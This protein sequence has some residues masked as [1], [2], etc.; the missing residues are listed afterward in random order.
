MRNLA[1]IGLVLAALPAPA[2]SQFGGCAV[3]G[4]WTAAAP[5]GAYALSM[6][7]DA[8]GILVGVAHPG[9]SPAL[10]LT[11]TGQRTG[12][13]LQLRIGSLA[14]VGAMTDC[15]TAPLIGVAGLTPLPL[16]RLRTTYCGDGTV[17]TAVEACDDGNFENG[18][19]CGIACTAN[20]ACGDVT[21][22]AGETCDDGN[23]SNRDGCLNGCVLAACGD[24]VLRD[25][26]EA[27][28]D[29]NASPS[30]GCAP[31]CSLE[32]ETAGGP[33]G[34]LV[35]SVTTDTEAG[36]DGASPSDP[37]ETTLSVP[38]ATVSGTLSIEEVAP[39]PSNAGWTFF[40]GLA[41]LQA[42]DVVPAP[43]ASNPLVVVFRVDASQIPAGQTETTI[44]VRKDSVTPPNLPK[45][46]GPAGQAVPDPCVATRERLGDGDVRLT[47]L[48]STLSTWN[49]GARTCNDRPRLGCWSA[50]P[51]KSKLKI[52]RMPNRDTLAWTWKDEL[53]MPA[54]PYGDPTSTTDYALCGYGPAGRLFSFVSPAGGTCAGKPCWVATLAGYKYRDPDGTPD[55]IAKLGLRAS[56]HVPR[57]KITTRAIGTTLALPGM[58]LI[59]P[60]H[61]Q[62]RSKDGPCFES[63]FSLPAVNDGDTFRAVGD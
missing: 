43:T 31:D 32:G 17:D 11:V 2:W 34:G 35:S 53:L 23:D 5:G 6:R 48:T 1:I 21:V 41:T 57:A 61:V 26:V 38:A 22:D 60:V 40:G 44:G 51:R 8:G 24:G 33:V 45:C 18:D 58:P 13:Q 29:G 52:K 54:S 14:F 7:E 28:D 62:L 59:G 25:G 39:P 47:I 12:P 10:R 50:D 49:F 46:G 63:T 55:G 56:S 19:A 20:S 36:G 15:D 16:V 4:T 30:D 42:T 37:I 9:G 3:T 27:C